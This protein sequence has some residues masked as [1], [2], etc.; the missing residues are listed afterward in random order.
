MSVISSSHS[1]GSNGPRPSSSFLISSI[2]RARSASVSSRPSSSRISLI[3]TVTF[4]EASGYTEAFMSA[5]EAPAAPDAGR[6]AGD[7]SLFQF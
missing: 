4:W 1:S 7:P 6:P 3:A 5:M 2:S